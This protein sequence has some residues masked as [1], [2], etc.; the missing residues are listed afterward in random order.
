M[1]DSIDANNYFY[2]GKFKIAKKHITSGTGQANNSRS[3]LCRTRNEGLEGT[4]LVDV[5]NFV[6]L[7]GGVPGISGPGNNIQN[8]TGTIHTNTFFMR[9]H[10]P[11]KQIFLDN[12]KSHVPHSEGNFGFIYYSG[13]GTKAGGIYLSKGNVITPQEIFNISQN[14]KLPLLIVLDMCCA[15]KFG[16]EYKELIN[17]NNW[18]GVII[19]SSKADEDSHE[20]TLMREIPVIVPGIMKPNL[21]F[22]QGIFSAAFIL[23]LKK[24]CSSSFTFQ[25]LIGEINNFMKEIRTEIIARGGFLNTQTACYF[26]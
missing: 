24:L 25:E 21:S 11:S 8:Y 18:R 13:H 19:C 23:A 10:L 26:K 22:G 2:N 15:G 4:S 14:L 3:P 6:N 12:L 5:Q 9:P 16:E 17:T 1:F 20:H 7:S